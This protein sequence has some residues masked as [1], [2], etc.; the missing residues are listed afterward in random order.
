MDPELI[1]LSNEAKEE[2]KKYSKKRFVCSTIMQFMGEKEH[3]ALVGPRGVGK[4]IVLKQLLAGRA[5]AFYVSLDTARLGAGLFQLAK[6]LSDS[7]ISLLLLDEI[8]GYPGYD[9]ELKKIYDFL[10]IKI[11]LTSSSSLMLHELAADL[12]RRIRVIMVHPFSFREYLFFKSGEIL[13]PLRFGM[14]LDEN[15]SK[16]YYA[17]TFHAEPDFVS[18]LQGGNY[19]IAIGRQDI[20]PLLRNV[21]EAV[22]NKDIIRTGKITHDETAH[23]SRLVAYVGKSHPED[24]NYTSI[25]KNIGISRFKAEKYID[26]LEKAFVLNRVAPAGQSVMKEPKI[27]MAL[28]YRL[29]YRQYE[30]CIGAL[31]EDFFVESAIQLGLELSYLKTTRGEKT[32]DYSIEDVVFEIGGMSKGHSQFKGFKMHRKIILIQPGMLD[33]SRRPLLFIGLVEAREGF[34]PAR[35]N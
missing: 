12:S 26:L 9:A 10:N 21:L 2:G 24:M 18:Y 17:K 4:T 28:P 29:L 14:L 1:E 15:A 30:D 27:L 31:R 34:K 13:E 6:D 22:I 5:D 32:P 35:T 7:G 11:I 3:I 16:A 8:H 19:P 25:S 20:L 23:I 33:S